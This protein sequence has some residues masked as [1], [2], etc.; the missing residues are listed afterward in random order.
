MF[1]PLFLGRAYKDTN[2]RFLQALTVFSVVHNKPVI[3][4]TDNLNKS[5]KTN[6]TSTFGF[7]IIYTKFPNNVWWY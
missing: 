5:R 1:I 7:Y 4:A 2:V 3:D 6:S